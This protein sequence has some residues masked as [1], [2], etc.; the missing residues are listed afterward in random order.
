MPRQSKS[1]SGLRRG[2]AAIAGLIGLGLA[3]ALALQAA[4]SAMIRSNPVLAVQLSSSN[5]EAS[6]RLA[7]ALFTARLAETRDP[8]KAAAGLQVLA[9]Q[10][11]AS[12]PL[13]PQAIAIR[14]IGAPSEEARR[15][16]VM[17]GYALNRRDP[18]LQGVALERFVAENNT[19]AA[20][21]TLDSLLRVQPEQ[22][23]VLFP[24]LENAM[25]EPGAIGEFG[26][27][28][29]GTA[30]WHSDFLRT[31][32]RNKALHVNLA[33]V[34]LLTD[35]RDPGFDGQLLA[36]VAASGDL[37]MAGKLYRHISGKT[38]PNASLGPLD[39]QGDLP[40]FDWALAEESGFYASP[41]DSG[42]TLD[43][44]I[45]PGKGGRLAGRLIA[46]PGGAF[47]IGIE[48]NLGPFAEPEDFRLVARCAGSNV[49]LLDA[50]LGASK[51]AR[52]L[53]VTPP[54]DQCGFIWLELNGRAWRGE[55]DVRGQ[56]G[57]ITLSKR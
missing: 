1:L 33:Q 55:P 21:S 4:S 57:R 34:R 6:T 16:I 45:R 7:G 8:A 32:V 2:R 35:L 18:L 53:V 47:V 23:A 36:Y 50:P 9:D 49:T 12:T 3:V 28:L 13:S 31:A 42:A 17:A 26:R 24:V 48:P 25:A 14:A 37:A 43:V 52:Q 54:G 15:E 46:N 19:T 40:P 41:A 56:I 27:I 20:L 11:L 44:L 10:A 39:W 5:G 38:L 29:D 51:G 22:G 30:P